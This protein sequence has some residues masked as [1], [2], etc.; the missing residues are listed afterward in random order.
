MYLSA[1]LWYSE[2]E[3]WLAG[4]FGGGRWWDPEEKG[5]RSLLVRVWG[6]PKGSKSGWGH[7]DKGQLGGRIP[8]TD[9]WAH[10]DSLHSGFLSCPMV[11]IRVVVGAIAGV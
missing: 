1:S 7:R 8:Q 3:N 6:T 4:V 5:S 11:S 10:S 9:T 2:E